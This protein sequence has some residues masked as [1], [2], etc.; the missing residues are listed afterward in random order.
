LDAA[1]HDGFRRHA[2]A[3]GGGGDVSGLRVGIEVD[4]GAAG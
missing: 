2:E 1:Y 4:H 3:C